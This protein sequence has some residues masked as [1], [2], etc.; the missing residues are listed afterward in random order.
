[1]PLSCPRLQRLRS[2]GSSEQLA[3]ELQQQ[4]DDS[5]AALETAR[6]TIE[7]VEQQRNVVMQKL[8][9]SVQEGK[10]TKVCNQEA[11]RRASQPALQPA[12]AF[13]RCS[14]RLNRTARAQARLEEEARRFRHA[15]DSQR[16]L[17]E[18]AEEGRAADRVGSKEEVTRWKTAAQSARH[19]VARL[20]NLLADQEDL[21]A[22]QAAA[23]L[24]AQT[25]LAAAT[26][27]KTGDA[28]S[29]QV[30]APLQKTFHTNAD[31]VS[32]RLQS[33]LQMQLQL[34][35]PGGNHDV[36]KLML[37]RNARFDEYDKARWSAATTPA[38][39]AALHSSFAED[40]VAIE[41][42]INACSGGTGLKGSARD[43]VSEVRP[44]QPIVGSP[45][46]R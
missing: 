2:P 37:V 12:P 7:E 44:G 21:R 16:A 4:L 13:S 27:D 3:A 46:P 25:A 34:A 19:E 36:G 39:R 14:S 35:D 5:T 31:H 17:T 40:V 20:K 45:H 11:A 41:E 24:A 18:A 8:R 15:V 28:S 22:A 43:V 1:M 23:L 38:Q 6:S 10:E 33:G 42:A 30:R 9:M 32:P 26:G 29:P